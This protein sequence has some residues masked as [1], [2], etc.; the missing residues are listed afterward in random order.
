MTVSGDH[1]TWRDS[2]VTGKQIL[3]YY[4]LEYNKCLCFLASCS[5]PRKKE[6]VS[7]RSEISSEVMSADPIFKIYPESYNHNKRA[8]LFSDAATV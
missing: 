3:R 1:P 6:R 5:C 4:G 7:L 2:S 8:F